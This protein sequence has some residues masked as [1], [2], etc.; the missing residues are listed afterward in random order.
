MNQWNLSKII[1]SAVT[2]AW[3]LCAPVQTNAAQ[4][5]HSPWGNLE[6]MV[7]A[8]RNKNLEEVTQSTFMPFDASQKFPFSQSVV[9]LRFTPEI[10]NST[11]QDLYLKILPALVTEVA[12]YLPSTKNASGWDMQSYKLS[13]LTAPIPFGSTA[14]EQDIYVRVISSLDARILPIVDLKENINLL[15][16]RSEAYIVC[17]VTILSVAALLTLAR[18]VIGFNFFSLALFSF[19][20]C[21]A[22]A[23]LSTSELLSLFSDWRIDH[24]TEMFPIA[25]TGSIFS[26]FAVWLMLANNLFNGGRWIKASSIFFLIFGLIFIGSFFD[27]NKAIAALEIARINSAWIC[28]VLLVLQAIQS[29]HL[30]VKKSEKLIFFFLV[31]IAILPLPSAGNFYKPIIDAFKG[32]DLNQADLLF[33]LRPLLSLMLLSLAAWSFEK[34]RSERISSLKSELSQTKTNLESESSRLDLQKKFTAMLT[35]ELKNPLMAS[36]MALGSI[37]DRLHEEDPSI[38]RVNSIGHSLQEID[39]IIERCAEIDKYEQ[40][41][42]PLVIE[43]FPLGDLVCIVKASH[44]SERI[45]SIVRGTDDD[46]MLRSDIYYIKSILN[47]LLTN[48]LKYS[49]A[50]SLVELKLEYK[51]NTFK[52]ELCLSVSNEVTDETKPDAIRVFERYYRSESAK[53]QSGAGL[54]LWLAQSMAHAL[55]SHIHLRIDGSCVRFEFSIPA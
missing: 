19:F 50:E 31:V 44:P 32:D 5:A 17:I 47:N 8:T 35:H 48:A 18:F 34:L 43:K 13:N 38:H 33:L 36:Q 7:D 46:L 21:I 1:C 23:C 53:Q 41:Y 37:R 4:S 40:G 22:I 55:G 11:E 9:W 39:T 14:L 49:V 3:L 54:G 20:I 6:V 42:I 25:L 15:Q 10:K 28:L 24:A 12:V 27:A 16:R 2:T 45:Y 29:R 52:S 30:L 26:F 51:H